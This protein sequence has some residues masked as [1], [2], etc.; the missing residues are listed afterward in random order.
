VVFLEG[1][2]GREGVV[3]AV[4]EA[5]VFPARAGGAFLGVEVAGKVVVVGAEIGGPAHAVGV[6]DEGAEVEVGVVNGVGAGFEADE[7]GA[8]VVPGGAEQGEFGGAA[9]TGVERGGIFDFRIGI[10]DFRG[11]EPEGVEGDEAVAFAVGFFGGEGGGEER[12]GVGAGLG[13]AEFLREPGVGGR[14]ADGGAAIGVVETEAGGALDVEA[15]VGGAVEGGGLGEAEVGAE[16]GLEEGE[17]DD[18]VGG[19][20]IPVAGALGVGAVGGVGGH[21]EREGFHG[22]GDDEAGEGGLVVGEREG[23]AEEAA[24]ADLVPIVVGGDPAGDAFIG[25]AGG[26]VGVGG[27]G[28]A[29]FEQ[30][31]FE[32]GALVGFEVGVEPV[33]A[34][35]DGEAHLGDVEIVGR[36]PVGKGGD[37]EQLFAGAAEEAFVAG[38]AEGERAREDAAEGG[39]G[40][41][42]E[43]RAD[44][45]VLDGSGAQFGLG[46]RDE[47]RVELGA[48]RIGLGGGD[49]GGELGVGEEE[50]RVAGAE[51]REGIGGGAE[52][53]KGEE[54]GEK[55]GEGDGETEKGEG[56][57]GVAV[58][59]RTD[60]GDELRGARLRGRQEFRRRRA[61]ARTIIR[62]RPMSA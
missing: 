46:D 8:G 39:A 17:G 13:D 31:A 2:G 26:V 9:E 44:E 54:D 42:E 25:G 30:G 35:G 48:E 57:H 11:R 49:G 59:G 32:G 10:F 37:G 19:A 33:V 14:E 34:D 23:G 41:V 24:V 47:A 22:A 12:A 56:A 53:G 60:A 28:E 29:V 21:G 20:V 15:V 36:I 5:V 55:E 27:E 43:T 40:F 4:V 50:A 61:A 3:G 38:E 45:G 62:P 51:L 7:E 16:G 1:V 52:G 18:V 6:E 58:E